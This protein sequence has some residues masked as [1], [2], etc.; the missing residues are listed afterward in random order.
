MAIAVVNAVSG[1]GATSYTGPTV[2]GSDTFG[3]VYVSG[4]T[5]ITS[6]PTVTWDGVSMTC[7]A[8]AF[9]SGHGA[10]ICYLVNPASAG[11]IALSFTGGASNIT[12]SAASYS[13]VDQASPID[14]SATTTGTSTDV[15][16]DVTVVASNCWL[17]AG[18]NWEN[19]TITCGVGST[20][21]GGTNCYPGMDSN[22]TVGTGTQALHATQGVSAAFQIA[23][24]SFKPSAGA[25]SSSRDARF[26]PLL[27]VG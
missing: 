11:T 17:A 13:G 12:S 7:I 21:R 6:A 8:T 18:E 3:I 24:F 20:N 14:A 25:A 27:G 22:G 9:S 26:L 4:G 16:V 23:S 19:N 15:T 10:E 1:G 2:S 5:N